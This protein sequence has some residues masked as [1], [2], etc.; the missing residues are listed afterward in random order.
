[1]NSS[2]QLYE[3]RLN[4]VVD[5]IYANLDDTI[6]IENLA[7][8]ACLSPYH[9]HRIYTA[10]RGETIATT[11]RRLR[12]LRAAERLANS[13]MAIREIA[14]L[15]GY[16]AVEAFGRAFKD[17]Y[18]SAPAEYRAR[19]SHAAFARA[20]A[21]GDETAFP[22]LIE[23]ASALQLVGVAHRGS[24]MQIDQ[25][26]GTLFGALAAQSLL[27]TGPRMIGLFMDDPDLVP[28]EALRSIACAT[29][30]PGAS[31]APPLVTTTIAGGAHARLRYKGPYA[32]MRGAYRWLMGVWLPASGREAANAPI[33]EEYL[34]NPRDVAPTELL[35]DIYLPLQ[36]ADNEG[37]PAMP[38]GFGPP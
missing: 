9:W 8:V 18:G 38:A 16:S 28:Q 32:D 2:T 29:A 21:R 36:P 15:A 5:H 3:A 37:Q 17:A 31:P 19:G 11:I 20:E 34:N 6:T 4:R 14:G 12:L 26:F 22:V 35:T 13:A 23:P 25:A 10:M 30:A 33:F 1:M 24:Y 7:E 27:G